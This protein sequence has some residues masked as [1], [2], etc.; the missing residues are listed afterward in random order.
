MAVSINPALQPLEIWSLEIGKP[1]LFCPGGGLFAE[2]VNFQ[3]PEVNVSHL[4]QEIHC[5]HN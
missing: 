2:I 1:F 3:I 4:P 5:K